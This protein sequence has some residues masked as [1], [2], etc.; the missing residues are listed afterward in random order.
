MPQD[1]KNKNVFTVEVDGKKLELA[2]KKPNANQTRKAQLEYNKAFAEAIKS[3]ALLK[4]KL[5]NVLVEQGIW[6]DERQARYDEL[7]QNINDGE[8]KLAKGGIRLES[9]KDIAIDMRGDRWELRQLISERT[10]LETNT[11]EGQAENARFN[12]LVSSTL[13]YNDTGKPYFKDVEDYMNQSNDT[14][15]I[16]AAQK[17]AN[18]MYGLEE[19]YES[20]LPENEFLKEFDFVDE[21]LRLVNE[22]GKLVDI[23]GN[24]IDE[25]GRYVDSKG[26]PID[27]EGD[28]VSDDGKYAF[29]RAPFLDESGAPIVDEA[30]EEQEEKPKPKKR[31]RPKKK[32]EAKEDSNAEAEE[33][34]A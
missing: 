3:G 8:K 30:E 16:T 1:N 25:F 15:A 11:A 17:F 12:Y 31:G 26:N 27:K 4:A 14:V 10:E 18:M 23:E 13:V 21:K 5:N 7:I 28:Q 29:Q 9:A 2:L 19:D 32:V 6:N 22:E 33:A 24:E 20:T 34:E